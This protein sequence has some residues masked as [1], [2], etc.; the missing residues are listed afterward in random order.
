MNLIKEIKSQL[1]KSYQ[2]TDLNDIEL[3]E[4]YDIFDTIKYTMPNIADKINYEINWLNQ[5]ELAMPNITPDI[6]S[7]IT[8]ILS[9]YVIQDAETSEMSVS[10]ENDNLIIINIPYIQGDWQVAVSATLCITQSDITIVPNV[11][12]HAVT[13]YLPA[14]DLIAGCVFQ[15]DKQQ[16]SPDEAMF[17]LDIVCNAVP[18]L[19]ENDM[20]DEEQTSCDELKKIT[21]TS[22]SS[23]HRNYNRYI[24]SVDTNIWTAVFDTIIK[25]FN[26]L[27]HE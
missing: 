4:L 13:H 1:N 25:T 16:L 26:Q 19:L 21:C 8:E 2:T 15:K 10:I 27:P 18:C 7:K 6:M 3:S 12:R 9:D 22:V 24:K 14:L 17:A 20:M 23:H 5:I 11:N